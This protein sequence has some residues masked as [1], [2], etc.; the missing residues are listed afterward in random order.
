MRLPDEAT[1]L[2]LAGV[3]W[4]MLAWMLKMFIIIKTDADHGDDAD[5]DHGDAAD[6]DADHGDAAD[7]DHGD[8]ADADHDDAADADYG[9]AVEIPVAV[10]MRADNHRPC[11]E[12]WQAKTLKISPSGRAP[13]SCSENKIVT[14]I[15]TNRHHCHPC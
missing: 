1:I 13:S 9:D 10:L 2:I 14:V 15:I 11:R 8:D 6:A 5:A 7:A 4:V 3:A 12:R